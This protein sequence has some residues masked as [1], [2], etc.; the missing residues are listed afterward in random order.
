MAQEEIKLVGSFKDDI[1]PKLKKLNKEIIN[2]GRSFERF[3]KKLAPVTKSFAKMAMSAQQF[4]N[5]MKSQRSSIDNSARAM[6]EYSRQAGKMS[7]AMRKVTDQR[8]KAQRAM[9]VSRS[10]AR[11]GVKSAD[12]VGPRAFA[13]P[14]GGKGAGVAIG[15]AAGTSFM[16]NV[17]STAIGMGIANAFARGIQSL[18]GLLM[19]PFQKFG[20]MFAERIRDEMDDIKSA[21]GLY[22]LDMD[23][24]EQSGNERFFKNYNEALRFQEKLNISMAE[25][26][27][28]LPGVTSQ[29]VDTSRQ[30]TDTIQMVMDKNRE[31]FRDYGKL[32]GADVSGGGVGADKEAFRTVLQK[33]TEQVMLMSQGQTGGLPMHI[34]LQQLL[35]KE[36]D[37][38]GGLGM[39]GFVNKYRAAFQ[40]N[41]MLKNMLMRAEKDMAETGANSVERLKAIMDVFNKALPK[42]QINKMRGS[43]SGLMEGLR[44]GLLDPQAG[45]FGMSRASMAMAGDEADKQ[46]RMLKKNVDDFGNQLFL[47][48]K[49]VE[50]DAGLEKKLK[51]MGKE[52]EVGNVLNGAEFTAEELK[53]LGFKLDKTGKVFRDVNGVAEEI[54]ATS[55][56]TTYVF[57]QIR[58]TIAGFAPPLLEF[59][60]ILPHLFDPFNQITS[61]F[62]QEGGFRDQ[63]NKFIS[64]FN[65][66]IDAIDDVAGKYLSSADAEM[67]R[68]GNVLKGQGRARSAFA[69]TADLLMGLSDDS[70]LNKKL[71]DIKA[72][73]AK[74]DKASIENFDPIKDA[75]F[76]LKTL[77]ESDFMKQIGDMLGTVAGG[78]ARGVFDAVTGMFNIITEGAGANKLVQGFTD[79]F[80]GMFS[81]IGMSGVMDGVNKVL[82]G[83]FSKIGELIVTQGIPLIIKGL[84]SAFFAG[85]KAGPVGMFIS[86]TLLLGAVKAVTGLTG[87][88]ASAAIS[89]KAAAVSASQFSKGMFAKSISGKP[90]ADFI[91][92]AKKGRMA[93]AGKEFFLGGVKE[94]KSGRDIFGAAKFGQ[95]A[96]KGGQMAMLGKTITAGLKSGLKLG[97]VGGILKA[98]FGLAEGK[99]PLD[100]VS[101]GLASA[102]GSGDWRSNWHNHCSRHR[103][104]NRRRD[105]RLPWRHPGCG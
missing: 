48:T 66:Y 102:G 79:G 70:I 10:Q 73:M 60:G 23:L 35:A 67:Q 74:T 94:V 88:A 45:L 11:A 34:A 68:M 75:T 80:S 43:L 24:T 83:T 14:K 8:M 9:G 55:R 31:G 39:Q 65:K 61:V 47:I 84:I 28:S 25:S 53:K 91:A 32:L 101:E 93:K 52:F 99:S 95:A 5:A 87:A 7:S 104:G 1:T 64:G 37:N 71:K 50:V 82:V 97:A 2:I 103:H 42:E 20:S 46:G 17:A 6:R 89:M 13:S 57:E 21:G 105:R 36:K 49:G 72:N 78:I 26:A 33:Q 85:L 98:G 41:P 44:S 19:S 22:A 86:G 12:S 29:Y 54:G 56:S 58:E 62:N 77:I 15:R 40:K 81:D 59:V 30:L 90:S 38:K 96:T 4:S 92:G 18:K 3:N 63:A 100:A 51:E 16:Q 76:L 27:A 69:A